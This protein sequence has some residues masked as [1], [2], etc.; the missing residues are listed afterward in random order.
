MSGKLLVCVDCPCFRPCVTRQ[1]ALSNHRLSP[2]FFLLPKYGGRETLCPSSVSSPSPH[3]CCDSRQDSSPLSTLQTP[4]PLLLPSHPAS[5]PR[6]TFVSPWTTVPSPPICSHLVSP[7]VEPRAQSRP[8][9][10]FSEPVLS[11]IVPQWIC[12]RL[13]RLLVHPPPLHSLLPTLLECCL[14]GAPRRG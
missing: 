1:A 7:A 2:A 3:W 14:G 12:Q 6:G 11:L 8:H 10:C 9:L 4:E 5:C 13:T